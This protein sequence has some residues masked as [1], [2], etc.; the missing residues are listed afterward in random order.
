[1]VILNATQSCCDA[2]IVLADA[3]HAIHVPLPRFTF[4]QSMV[5]QNT[6][7]KLLGHARDTHSNDRFGN[8]AAR[9]G[10]SWESLLPGLWKGVVQPVLDALAFTVRD[11]MSLEFSAD[12][13]VWLRTDAWGPISNFLVSDWPF[14]V[15]SYPWNWFL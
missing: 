12:P 3:D 11:V 4:K 9:G 1:M 8:P 5:L 10:V 6:L 15:S 13:F 7:E 14:R 2:L